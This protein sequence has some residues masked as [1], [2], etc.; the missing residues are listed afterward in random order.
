MTSLAKIGMGL[1]RKAELSSEIEQVN[2][3]NN[4]LNVIISLCHSQSICYRCNGA[5][6]T[7]LL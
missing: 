5:L 1:K 3:K 4:K 7:C 2:E 6:V